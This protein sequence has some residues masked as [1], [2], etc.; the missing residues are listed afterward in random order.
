MQTAATHPATLDA[1]SLG[2]REL[3][4]RAQQGC[5]AS[6]GELAHR[7][8]GRLVSFLLR[9]SPSRADAEDAAQEAL[10]R[11][12]KNIGRYDETYRFSTWLFTIASRIASEQRR[13]VGRGAAAKQRLAAA[14]AGKARIERR[15]DGPERPAASDVWRT[16]EA[17]LARDQAEALWLRY[18]MEMGIGEIAEV[19]GRTRVGVRVMLFRAREKLAR[20]LDGAR[21][22]VDDVN[23]GGV[24]AATAP[25]GITPSGGRAAGGVS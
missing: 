19:M 7:F 9:R 5:V 16:A 3:A 10:M 17:I 2:E 23:S 15:E 1:H 8:E 14:G 25:V 22:G 18:A 20:A 12:W 11:A 24:A 4:R 21:G 6:F 13:A